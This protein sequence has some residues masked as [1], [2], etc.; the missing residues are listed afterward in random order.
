MD[1]LKLLKKIRNIDIARLYI[2]ASSIA[3]FNGHRKRIRNCIKNINNIREDIKNMQIVW[4]P[5]LSKEEGYWL[6]PFCNNAA[7]QKIIYYA[8]N[9]DVMWDAELPFRRSLII[10]NIIWFFKNKKL[11]LNFF[12]LH[13]GNIYVSEYYEQ[14]PVFE[15]LFRFLCL[16]FNPRKYRHTIIKMMYVSLRNFSRVWLRYNISRGVHKFGERFHVGLGCIGKGISKDERI[17]KPEDLKKEILLCKN[18]G[19]AEVVLYRLGGLNKEYISAIN[20]ALKP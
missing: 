3:E 7:L 9:A 5:V 13:K 16:S 15:V 12:R 18:I 11:I 2:A 14:D 20:D 17:L 19:V 4:W 6:S 1:K 8:K 10:K